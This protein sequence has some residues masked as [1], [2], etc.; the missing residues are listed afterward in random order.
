MLKIN[1]VYLRRYY[2]SRV[3]KVFDTIRKEEPLF[4][5]HLGDFHC[6]DIVK[7]DRA[8]YRRAFD[9]VLA[10]PVQFALY[11]HVPLVYVWE[12]HDFGPNDS[13]SADPGGSA[14][15]LT[16]RENVPHYPLAVGDGDLA[17]RRMC[18]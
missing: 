12:D 3:S 17:D 1:H 15:R 13:Y 11:R 4:F 14:A 2:A 16:Y 5:L 7:N 10:S 6:E 9:T 8:L 18:Q